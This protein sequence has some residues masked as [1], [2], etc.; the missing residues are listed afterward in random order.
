VTVEAGANWLNSFARNVRQLCDGAFIRSRIYRETVRSETGM[1]SF[2]NS[3]WI[4]GAPQRIFSA[5]MRR[6]RD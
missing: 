6:M 5:A 1:P 4:R 2:S 3:P